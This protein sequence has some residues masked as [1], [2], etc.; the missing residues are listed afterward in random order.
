MASLPMSS[1]TIK[2]NFNYQY[3]TP[4]LMR[5]MMTW[6]Q[7]AGLVSGVL[8]NPPKT[9]TGDLRTQWTMV[10]K[11]AIREDPRQGEANSIHLLSHSSALMPE[12]KVFLLRSLD[13]WCSGSWH[14]PKP[15]SCVWLPFLRRETIQLDQHPPL[16]AL[17]PLP[18][19]KVL[20]PNAVR[21]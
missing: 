20:S 17:N 3:K 6:N 10:T 5:K 19:F 7:V 14:P 15:F 16:W 12:V 2:G 9:S 1:L 13:S 4:L 11:A 21:Y 8:C 18:S